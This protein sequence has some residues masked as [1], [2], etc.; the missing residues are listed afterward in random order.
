MIFTPGN[1]Y[2][3]DVARNKSSKL[4]VYDLESVRKKGYG[5]MFPTQ[6]PFIFLQREEITVLNDE[7]NST[8]NF[9]FYVNVFFCT[10]IKKNVAITETASKNLKEL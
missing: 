2:I 4:S 8:I 6:G 9:A 5:P 1:T 3:L 10:D 7:L